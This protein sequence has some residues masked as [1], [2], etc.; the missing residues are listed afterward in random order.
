[1]SYNKKSPGVPG[2]SVCPLFFPGYI[3]RPMSKLTIKAATSVVGTLSKPSKMPCHGYSI[4]AKYCLI[5]QKLRSVI[6]SVCN[7]CYALKGRYVFPDVL[8]AME[9]RFQ[10][11]IS[12]MWV[13]LMTF[14]I[15]KQ[16]KSGFFRWHDS[17]DLQGVWHLKKIVDI[18]RNLPHIK[19]W[20]PTREY[21]FVSSY[22]TTDTIPDNL[23]IRLSALMIDGPA[24]DEIARKNN[25]VVSGV[26][27]HSSYNCPAPSQ[28]N[29]CGECRACWDKEVYNVNYKK[30]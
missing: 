23:T 11:L 30:H 17:G 1:M 19:F 4:P 22:L 24:P 20:L 15:D 25:L 8:A 9:K 28:G 18:A 21:A 13:C 2:K 10:S 26:S 14:I 7:K 6:G 29:F 12:P 3:C 27:H 16:E 5:G